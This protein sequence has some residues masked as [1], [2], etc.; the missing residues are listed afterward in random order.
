MALQSFRQSGYSSRDFE[1]QSFDD[2]IRQAREIATIEKK[3]TLGWTKNFQPIVNKNLKAISRTF[4]KFILDSI[5]D[6]KIASSIAIN[7]VTSL[8]TEVLKKRIEL[9]EDDIRLFERVKTAF[10]TLSETFREKFKKKNGNLVGARNIEEMDF[11]KPKKNYG[12]AATDLEKLVERHT[13]TEEDYHLSKSAETRQREELEAL[14]N[15]L[16]KDA[17]AEAD[18]G[19]GDG[20]RQRLLEDRIGRVGLAPELQLASDATLEFLKEAGFLSDDLSEM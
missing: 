14:K 5:T 2:F 15:R 16:L 11:Y 12:V 13:H 4:S 6:D 17:D 8:G 7:W 20:E 1:K 9:R 19:I 18:D 10:E 3:D